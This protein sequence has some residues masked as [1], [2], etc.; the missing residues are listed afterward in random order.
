MGL[1]GQVCGVPFDLNFVDYGGL[2]KAS[3]RQSTVHFSSLFQNLP[4]NAKM[5]MRSRVSSRG[6]Q[7][8]IC[9]GG[10][11]DGALGAITLAEPAVAHSPPHQPNRSI[12]VA[13]A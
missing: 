9:P 8:I 7:I 4:E 3:A 13:S 6:S 12:K 10:N 2:E 1:P 11:A 5:A